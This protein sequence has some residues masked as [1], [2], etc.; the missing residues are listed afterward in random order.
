[1]LR[2]LR[3]KSSGKVEGKKKASVDKQW[4]S[5]EINTESVINKLLASFAS[6]LEPMLIKNNGCN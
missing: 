4:A 3:I 6:V 1:M 5:Q 2:I